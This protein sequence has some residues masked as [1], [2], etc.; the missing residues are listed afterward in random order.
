MHLASDMS[1]KYVV[2][3]ETGLPVRLRICRSCL[4]PQITY[5]QSRRF[6]AFAFGVP[7]TLMVALAATL[8]SLD[9]IFGIIIGGPVGFA[10]A[11]SAILVGAGILTAVGAS[12]IPSS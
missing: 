3:A 7:R 12:C 11:L 9:V 6:P 1:D 8:A 4:H 5:I 10:V 2:N